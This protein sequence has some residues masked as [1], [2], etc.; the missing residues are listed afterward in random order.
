MRPLFATRTGLLVR[1]ITLRR[2]TGRPIAAGMNTTLLAVLYIKLLYIKLP[3]PGGGSVSVK[4]MQNFQA[5]GLLRTPRGATN[6]ANSPNPRVD[7]RGQYAAS[8]DC[9]NA[10]SV[11]HQEVRVPVEAAVHSRNLTTCAWHDC[12]PKNRAL[13]FYVHAL[14]TRH[15]KHGEFSVMHFSTDSR[16]LVHK[17][18]F[19]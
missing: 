4:V 2:R 13:F 10:V 5:T 8:G 14:C 3:K 15:D 11:I 7:Y 18:V 9:I 19:N 17:H 12:S 6:F 16:A 1:L